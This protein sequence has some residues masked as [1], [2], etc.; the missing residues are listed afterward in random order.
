MRK[1]IGSLIYRKTNAYLVKKATCVDLHYNVYYLYRIDK[2]LGIEK[3]T[4]VDTA[5]SLSEK[6][7]NYWYYNYSNIKDIN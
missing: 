6:K 4:L 7:K 2:I 1:K 3:Y 5:S